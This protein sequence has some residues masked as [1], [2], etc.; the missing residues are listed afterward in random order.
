M[1]RRPWLIW[2]IVLVGVVLLRL[3]LLLL[4]AALVD[5]LGRSTLVTLAL[6]LDACYLA[7]VVYGASRLWEHRVVRAA[8]Y[9]LSVVWAIVVCATFYRAGHVG[10]AYALAGALAM[11][12]AFFLGLWLIRL[13]L[14]PGLGVTGV[15]RTFVDEAIRLRIALVFMIVLL[16]IVP[17]L[18][19]VLDPNELLRYRMQFFL[20]WSYTAVSVLLSLMVV[21]VACW[22]VCN[23]ISERQ[24]YLT[25][26]KPVSRLSYLLGKWLGIV[27]L[28]AVLV[29]VS[30]GGIYVFAQ[31]LSRQT[32]G[33]SKSP[34]EVHE[35]VLTARHA[36]DPVPPGD[37]G[38]R[39]AFEAQAA[40]LRR[41]DPDVYG[42]RLTP[43]QEEAIRKQVMLRWHTIPSRDA[44][45]YLF[46]G[47]GPAKAITSTVQLR[48]KAK[49]TAPPAEDM[50]VLV[51]QVNGR[52][53]P[54]NTGAS[55]PPGYVRIANDT[56]YVLD[57]PTEA[58]DENGHLLVVIGNDT[59]PAPPTQNQT[60]EPAD[61]QWPSVSF[62]PG[63][64]LQMLYRVGTFEGNLVRAMIM[65][66]LRLAFLAMLGIAAG[67]FLTFP[68]ACLLCL[69]VFFSS[70]GS[71]YLNESISSYAGSAQ[72]DAGFFQS[73]AWPF[74]EIG[75][76]LGE[77]KWWTAIKIV[78]KLVGSGF[79]AIVPA[80]GDYTP[81]HN[82]TDGR[83]IP[84]Q[85]LGRA[86]LWIGLVWTAAVGV[87]GYLIFRR[88][89]LARV[90]V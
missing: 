34:R 36:A 41:E 60:A 85:W 14:S 70:A 65:L 40:Q 17:V 30:G 62:T 38:L 35:Q 63:E 32:P 81:V 37:E 16:L 9:G 47:L 29:S 31:L 15:A 61:V 50:V 51:I 10:V 13:A 90:T 76:A 6:F 72:K 3:P 74:I 1:N 77:G 56:V 43:E 7:A 18:P 71:G 58:I 19:F 67:T 88:R 45:P 68:V 24:V 82:L 23:D 53:W 66:W 89:E 87:V 11:A 73:I 49:A 44:R 12:G 28:S 48:L 86:A 59:P 83:V 4:T 42:E 33:P 20:T 69:V 57:I 64:G 75:K 55:L 27:L 8:V 78:I 21:F 2:L 80:L 79:M 54:A 84:W 39:P 26:T 25:M 22:T 52:P 5:R 46:K